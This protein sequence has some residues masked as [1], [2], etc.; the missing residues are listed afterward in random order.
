[1]LQFPRWRVDVTVGGDVVKTFYETATTSTAA[2]AKAKHK[3]RGAVSSAGT[4][5]FKAMK[6][7]EPS[8]HHATKKKSPAQLQREIDE[9]LAG[10]PTKCTCP[11]PT[12]CTRDMYG[13]CSDDVTPEMI[14]ERNARSHATKKSPATK[15]VVIDVAFRVFPEGDVIALFPKQEQ[16][17]DEGRGQI[18]SYQHLGQHGGADRSLLRMKKAAPSQYASLLTE[19]KSLGYVP[20]ILK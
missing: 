10:L 17:Q 6:A 16:E 13:V 7:D 18:G 3:M 15:R 2:I 12:L 1:M 8:G 14:A 5:R 20:R 19:L 11:V 9:T 4:F